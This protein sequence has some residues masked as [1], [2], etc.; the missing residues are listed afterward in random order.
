[1]TENTAGTEIPVAATEPP[2]AGTG[3]SQPVKLP[4]KTA[5]RVLSGYERLILDDIKGARMAFW[6]V[7]QR[8]PNSRESALA[9][10][11]LEEAEM[12]AIKGVLG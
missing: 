10:T 12:W 8:M 6:T 3:I 4:A 5:E 7:L 2:P 9:K 11:K 1:M